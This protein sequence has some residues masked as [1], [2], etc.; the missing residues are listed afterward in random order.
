[1]AKVKAPLFSLGA[2]GSIAKT[3]VYGGWKGLN[4]V[5][6][7]VVPTNPNTAPQQTQRTYMTDAVSEFHGAAYSEDAITAWARLAGA[8][9]RV[10][11][12]FNR[13][14]K[15]FIDEAVAGNTWDRIYN[16]YFSGATDTAVFSFVY[17]V[18]GGNTPAVRYG[19]RKTYMPTVAGMDDQTGDLWRYNIPGLTPNTLYYAYFDVGTS[20]ADY[21]RTGIHTFRTLAS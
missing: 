15:E 11:T 19:T 9:G 2:S 13:M 4:T 18:S 20:G 7:H 14:V 3:L 6:E 1:M 5:R 16:P 12:G 8:E 17:K 21:G 10:M